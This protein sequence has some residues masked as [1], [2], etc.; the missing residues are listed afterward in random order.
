MV[1]AWRLA[2]LLTAAGVQSLAAQ[3]VRGALVDKTNGSGIAGAF[4]VLVDQ[5]GQ[6]VARVL[7]GD[8]GAFLLRAPGPGAYRLQSKR[9]GFHV[10]ASP[11]FTLAVGQVL[12]YRLE[13]QAIPV[14][15]PP[16]VVAGRPQ[17]G[18]RGAQG[19]V[20]A[21]LWEDAREALAGVKWTQ[22]QRWY[23]YTLNLYERNLDATGRHIKREHTTTQTGRAETPFR[24]IPAESLA[25][26]GYVVG[27]DRNG[28]IY[29]GP[30]PDVLLSD[31]FLETHCFS[32]RQGTGVDSGLVG[33][34]FEPAPRR[35]LPDIRGVLWVSRRTAELRTLEFTYVNLPASLQDG[36]SRGDE[37][38]LRLQTGAWVILRWNIRMPRVNEFVDPSGRIAPHFAVEGYN[39]TGG[40]V[41]AI[42]SS[43]GTLVYAGEQAILDGAVVD[44]T[45]GGRPLP[46][47]IVGLGGTSYA[48]RADA[49]GHFQLAAPLDGMYDVVFSA[50]RLDSLG[51]RAPPRSVTLTRG[52]RTLVTL[53]VPPEPQLVAAL[54][55]DGLAESE[56]VIVGVVT[57]GRARSAVA[58]ATVR[59]TWQSVDKAGT[60]LTTQPWTASVA[61]DSTGHYVLC[62]VPAATKVTLQA[63]SAQARSRAVALRFGAGGVWIEERAF[64]SQ[65]GPIWTQD[66]VLAP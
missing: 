66:L 30:D 26:A 32:A 35:R 44:S 51:G 36:T 8:A 3:S 15:L 19:T 40:Q 62:G 49:T 12:T 50:P 31:A 65:A 42:R 52:T 25:T 41:S 57:G 37:D 14:E 2:L 63:D 22:G 59:A 16:V 56:V 64:R 7:T 48:T 29:Y 55:P 23:R 61:A 60:L 38:F 28:R 43:G 47:A 4:V 33:L 54:C 1:G 53:A 17:C 10:A 5:R 58:G 27:D 11:S 21:Q 34:A 46:G 6:E 13:V 20:V 45:R 9:I 39:E 18:T 24:S